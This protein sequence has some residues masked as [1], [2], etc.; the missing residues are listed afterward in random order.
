MKAE[1]L[2]GDWA[3][4]APHRKKKKKKEKKRE[5]KH[6]L[7]RQLCMEWDKEISS[8]SYIELRPSAR[9]SESKSKYCEFMLNLIKHVMWCES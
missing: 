7:D 2:S 3:S 1:T 6:S 4:L 9:Q 8:L 5:K